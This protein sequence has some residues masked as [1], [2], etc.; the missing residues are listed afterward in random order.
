MTKESMSLVEDIFCFNFKRFFQIAIMK[1]TFLLG[2]L[3][4]CLNPLLA[5]HFPYFSDLSL[6]CILPWK[7]KGSFYI[8]METNQYK[9]IYILFIG[10]VA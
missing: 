8:A 6:C 2:G 4:C 1:N 7:P 3:G 9:Y 10:Q 5:E